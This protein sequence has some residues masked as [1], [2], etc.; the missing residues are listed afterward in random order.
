[1]VTEVKRAFQRK[2]PT[3]YAVVELGYLEYT[4]EISKKTS[5]VYV[6]VHEKSIYLFWWFKA[7]VKT[8][9]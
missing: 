6:S 2:T 7:K 9:T 1:L 3:V 4:S 8:L 5:V